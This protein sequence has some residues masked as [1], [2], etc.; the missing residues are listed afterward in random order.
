MEE[1]IIRKINLKPLMN[2]LKYFRFE[3][4]HALSGKEKT[5]MLY[6]KDEMFYIF[7]EHSKSMLNVDCSIYLK[8]KRLTFTQL[9][10]HLIDKKS[11][12]EDRLNLIADRIIEFGEF[13]LNKIIVS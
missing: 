7:I 2:I 4:K 9:N 11:L 10:A 12:V 3:R 13:S 5:C 1:I 6:V 8:G